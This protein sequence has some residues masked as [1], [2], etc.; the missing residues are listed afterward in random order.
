MQVP[1]E[2]AVAASGLQAAR[3]DQLRGCVRTCGLQQCQQRRQQRRSRSS[4]SSNFVLGSTESRMRCSSSLRFC[5]CVR[6]CLPAVV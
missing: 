1:E 5:S 2:A 4:S 6:T 3:E